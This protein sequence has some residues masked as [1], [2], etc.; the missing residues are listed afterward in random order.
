M[1]TEI[2]LSADLGLKNVHAGTTFRRPPAAS[3][4][5][6]LHHSQQPPSCQEFSQPPWDSL[7]MALHVGD[8]EKTVKNNRDWVSQQ[9]Q[10]PSEP[11]W[12]DQIHGDAIV[13]VRAPVQGLGTISGKKVRA[14][15]SYTIEKHHVLAILTAD[16]LPVIM[17][18]ETENWIAIAHCGWR[19]LAGGLLK[20]LLKTAP[21]KPEGIRAWLGPA[22]SQ[23]HFQ[24]GDDVRQAF[25]YLLGDGH[26]MEHYFQEDSEGRFR[27]DLYGLARLQLARCGI[28]SISGGER[29]TFSEKAAFYS[30]RREPVTGRMLSFIWMD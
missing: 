21:G 1:T 20:N 16:C 15:G 30:Y 19:S 14:D 9:L 24:V 23:R 22:I 12:L 25:A 8:D 7:N 10:F 2:F 17:A 26:E 11:Y 29:C 18:S 5:T 3:I 6:H 4:F 27:A 28:R 13:E